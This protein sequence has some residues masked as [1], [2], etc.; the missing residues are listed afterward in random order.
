M[1][2]RRYLSGEPRFT[3]IFWLKKPA[4]KFFMFLGS[5]QER[6]NNIEKTRPAEGTKNGVT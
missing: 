1:D 5:A 3:H 4:L 6:K 2:R